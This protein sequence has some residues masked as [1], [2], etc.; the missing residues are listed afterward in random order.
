[1]ESIK[2]KY[3]IRKYG[4]RAYK[5]IEILSMVW[6]PPMILNCVAKKK[7]MRR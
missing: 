5:Q 2:E 3:K 7:K 1:M 4:T 6:F